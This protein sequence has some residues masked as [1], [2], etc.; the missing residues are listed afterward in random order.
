MDQFD[1]GRGV[2]TPGLACHGEDS[3][4]PVLKPHGNRQHG[5]MLV[6]RRGVRDAR[7]REPRVSPEIGTPER[8]LRR[9]HLPEE[10]FQAYGARVCQDSVGIPALYRQVPARIPHRRVGSA[11]ERENTRYEALAGRIQHERLDSEKNL[12][13]AARALSELEQSEGRLGE[14]LRALV[15]A[16]ATARERQEKQSH[17]VRA[18]A[19]QI[20]QRTESLTQLLERLAALGAAAGDVN[21]LVQQVAASAGEAGAPERIDDAAFREIQDRLGRLAEDSG[22]LARAAQADE[23]GDLGTQAESLRLQLLSARNKFVLLERRRGSAGE[24]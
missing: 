8:S 5:A 14:H 20:R 17:S 13:Q 9:R 10:A 1:V 11:Q 18:R 16:I 4:H 24:P 23:F 15:D 3:E 22:E 21:R 6:P 2:G 7:L 19:E 12:H